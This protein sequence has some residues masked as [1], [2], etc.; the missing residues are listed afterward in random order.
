MQ[1]DYLD[2]LF[3]DVD[4]DELERLREAKLQEDEQ[5]LDYDEDDCEGCKI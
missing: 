1:V 5:P 3:D 4:E 2:T